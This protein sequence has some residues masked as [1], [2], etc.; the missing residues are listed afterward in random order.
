MIGTLAETEFGRVLVLESPQRE[1]Q[2]LVVFADFAEEIARRFHFER[3]ND[4]VALLVD[5]CALIALFHFSYKPAEQ[6][7]TAVFASARLPSPVL[8]RMSIV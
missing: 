3:V 8:T 7:T 2:I 1:R 4:I 6:T 5:G